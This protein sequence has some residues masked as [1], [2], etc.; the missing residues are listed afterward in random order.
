MPLRVMH[1]D[2][3]LEWRYIV[4]DWY[5]IGSEYE[6]EIS[7]VADKAYTNATIF[8]DVPNVLSISFDGGFTYD[9][10]PDDELNGLNI[11]TFTPGQRKDAR[12]KLYIASGPVRK[13]DFKLG[14][15]EGT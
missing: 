11:G 14:F 7:V 13:A 1:P 12:L 3:A 4:F 10:I 8:T 15:G 6:V 9:P 5:R 2:G